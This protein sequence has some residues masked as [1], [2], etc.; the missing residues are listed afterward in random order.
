M[1]LTTVS[2]LEQ[3]D[4][5]ARAVVEAR[6]AACVQISEITSHYRWQGAVEKADE[7][8]LTMKTTRARSGELVDWVRGNHPYDV[9]EA[10]VVPVS[11]AGFEYHEWVGSSVE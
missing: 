5:L 7:R 2:S 11:A 10:M 1:V 3:A 4:E 6:L 9:P 8:L